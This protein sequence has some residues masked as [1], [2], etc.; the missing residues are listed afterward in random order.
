M[1]ISATADFA[2]VVRMVRDDFVTSLVTS[3]L[4]WKMVNIN[5]YWYTFKSIL[6]PRRSWCQDRGNL[7]SAERANPSNFLSYH[8]TVAMSLQMSTLL[9]AWPH[10]VCFAVCNSSDDVESLRHLPLRWFAGLQWKNWFPTASVETPL[11]GCQAPTMQLVN[12]AI[13]GLRTSLL[14]PR[15]MHNC[16]PSVRN[17]VA[18]LFSERLRVHRGIMATVLCLPTV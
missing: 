2:V 9:H 8:V 3:I 13:R 14:F 1:K 12:F 18:E 10:P 11:E 15:C 6:F 5:N 4:K 16:L 7:H 17:I